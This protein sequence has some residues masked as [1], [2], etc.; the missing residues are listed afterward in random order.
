M[1]YELEDAINMSVLFCKKVLDNYTVLIYRV[2]MIPLHDEKRCGYLFTL[3][4]IQNDTVE[5]E[6]L[7][8]VTSDPKEAEHIFNL[9]CSNN[10]Y[11]CHL[12]T[13]IEDYFSA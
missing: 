7:Y 13:V 12:L 11:P 6:E 2:D 3:E 10:V 1:K 4:Q 8:D 9:I 5:H